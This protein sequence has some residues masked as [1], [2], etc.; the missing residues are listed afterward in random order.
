MEQGYTIEDANH[1]IATDTMI[2]FIK[3]RRLVW[4]TKSEC[5]VEKKIISSGKNTLKTTI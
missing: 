1:A 4:I 5:V 2:S 3:V